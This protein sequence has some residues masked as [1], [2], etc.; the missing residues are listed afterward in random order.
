MY[1]KEEKPLINKIIFINFIGIWLLIKISW[2]IKLVDIVKSTTH[3]AHLLQFN[4][5][6]L[7]LLSYSTDKSGSGKSADKVHKCYRI[8]KFLN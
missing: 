1:I 5:I 4:P 6:K 2:I 8:N 3:F 7:A